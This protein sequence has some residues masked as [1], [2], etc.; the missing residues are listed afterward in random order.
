MKSCNIC[1]FLS[2]SREKVVMEQCYLWARR[3][4]AALWKETV[5][6]LPRAPRKRQSPSKDAPKVPD[7]KLVDK[8]RALISEG[9]PRKALNLLL[10]D[11]LHSMEDQAVRK[12]LGELHPDGDLVDTTSLPGAVDDGLPAPADLDVWSKGVLMVLMAS[13]PLLSGRPSDGWWGR[14]S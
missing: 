7:S 3:D 5:A 11:G 14:C 10:S 2:R 1:T 12:R 13:G 8:M 4:Y 6:D 9:A